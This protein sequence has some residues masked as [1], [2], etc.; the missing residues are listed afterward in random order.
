MK[1]LSREFTTRE[2]VLLLILAILMVF[3]VY[4]YLVDIPLRS[5]KE[6]LTSQLDQLN[7]DYQI[8]HAK[9]QEHLKMK[10]DMEQ[11]TADTSIMASYN[12]RSEEIDFLDE[13]FKG[14][15]QYSV[16]FSPVTVEGDQIRRNFTVSFTTG[17]YEQAIAILK[18]LADCHYRCT[19]NDISCSGNGE[20]SLSGTVTVS[21]GATFYETMVDRNT[22]A[23]LP[24]VE[25]PAV[26]EDANVEPSE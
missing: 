15:S 22:D 7:T 17:S 4:Y 16:G 5:Q 1:H 21:C 9:Y 8:T 14:T 20:E 10:S 18:K 6:S 13:I 26:T 23:G 19:V 11:V 2:K 12:N 25:A 3:V 24:V